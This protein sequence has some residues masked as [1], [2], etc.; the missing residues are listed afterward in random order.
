MTLTTIFI[1]KTILYCFYLLYFSR[2]LFIITL[3]IIFTSLKI[4]ILFLFI[5]LF[6]SKISLLNNC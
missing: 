6:I 4:I 2:C 1:P 3:P 5:S